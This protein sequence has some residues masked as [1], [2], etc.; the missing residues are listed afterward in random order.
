MR[1]KR[2]VRNQRN[3]RKTKSLRKRSVSKRNIRKT[4]RRLSK[5]RSLRKMRSK[6]G[7][8]QSRKNR[9]RRITRKRGGA[10][11]ISPYVNKLINL[12]F[13]YGCDNLQD[14]GNTRKELAD[15]GIDGLK[16]RLKSCG[17]PEDQ[18]PTP[19]LDQTT[20]EHREKLSI[21]STAT[22]TYASSEDV[23]DFIALNGVE[24]DK[25]EDAKREMKVDQ[26]FLTT[27]TSSTGY[28]IIFKIEE[29]RGKEKYVAFKINKDGD[30]FYFDTDGKRATK[31]ETLKKLLEMFIDHSFTSKGK[32]YILSRE[33][34]YPIPSQLIPV[35]SDYGSIQR[36]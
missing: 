4:N 1:S 10:N 25:V 6:G 31:K 12:L 8:K 20:S 24:I 26:W 21:G 36:N 13:T 3:F 28:K 33:K 29:A 2:V 11:E 23:D 14:L 5:S 22:V 17:V 9:K 34:Q 18:M 35:K 32:T 7:F 19:G 30:S 15:E 16:A 27:S